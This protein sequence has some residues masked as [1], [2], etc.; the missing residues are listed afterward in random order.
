MYLCSHVDDRSKYFLH[1]INYNFTR[2]HS[3]GHR[4]ITHLS[5]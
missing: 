4:Y 5:K 2:S 3:C 1:I